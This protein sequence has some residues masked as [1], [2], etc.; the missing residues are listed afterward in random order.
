VQ[1]PGGKQ[2]WQ[3]GCCGS[4]GGARLCG[5][6]EAIIVEGIGIKKIHIVI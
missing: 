2:R 6:E 3:R 5:A 1:Y 4:V